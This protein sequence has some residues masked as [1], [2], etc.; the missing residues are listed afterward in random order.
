M[1]M[2]IVGVCNLTAITL[3]GEGKGTHMD[4]RLLLT[5]KNIIYKRYRQKANRKF[6]QSI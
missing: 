2:Y 3:R 1:N 5:I 4:V 6:K